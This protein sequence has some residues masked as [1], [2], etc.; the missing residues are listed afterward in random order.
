V[1]LSN[2]SGKLR[3]TVRLLLDHLYPLHGLP[4]DKLFFHLP[5]SDARL[6]E[7][8]SLRH[9]SHDEGARILVVGGFAF[10]DY[11]IGYKRSENLLPLRTDLTLGEVSNDMRLTDSPVYV[12]GDEYVFDR[13][14]TLSTCGRCI[15]ILADDEALPITL[16]NFSGEGILDKV[17]PSM[18]CEA[19]FP[20]LKGRHLFRDAKSIEIRQGSLIFQ[21][22][23]YLLSHSRHSEAKQFLIICMR[24]YHIVSPDQ[25]LPNGAEACCSGDFRDDDPFDLAKAKV[26]Q[27][28]SSPGNQ[29]E[30]RVHP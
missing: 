25:R 7:N 2:K 1:K 13:T 12:V 18:K 23:D 3:S 11:T 28:W 9:F 29:I 10:G 14:R 30:V 4:R 8:P 15:L 19:V 24:E 16:L 20:R 22:D 27:I 26:E 17:C 5:D 6:D 21:P